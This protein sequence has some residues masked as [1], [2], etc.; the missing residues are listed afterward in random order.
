MQA[1]RS[2]AVVAGLS[3]LSTAGCS[4]TQ[5]ETQHQM[6]PAEVAVARV[7][8][9]QLQNF[10][11]FSG[12]LEAMNNVELHPQVEGTVNAIH[13]TEGAHVKKGELLF[14]ID[15]RRFQQ[16]VGRLQ[17]EERRAQSELVL[18]TS[19]RERSERLTKSGAIAPV[20]LE[21]NNAR[22]AEAKAALDSTKASLS[23]ARLDLSYAGVRAPI[24]G[25]V[26]RAL[27]T[28]GNLVTPATALTTLVSDGALYVYFD[29]DEA[30]YLAISR[31]PKD[32]KI[33]RIGLMDEEGYQHEGS[34]DFLDNRVDPRSG[35]M[36]ARA[37]IDNV[38]GRLMPG[39]FTRV[40]LV[41]GG[42]AQVLLVDDKAVLT[43]QDRKYVYVVGEGNRAQRKTIVIG[44]VADGLR[45]VQ[46]GL[47]PTDRVVVHGVQKIFFPGAPLNPRDIEMGAPP[48]EPIAAGPG[49]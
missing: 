14:E 9:K 47:E 44:R 29:I 18:A 24:D 22:E 39:L 5:A 49:H 48:P 23:L 38:D 35:T 10:S 3:L 12:R 11:D 1:I 13:F 45:V 31:G 27:V 20:E 34:L 43:D 36:H 7:V 33:V 8:S 21:R 16:Q 25:R 28:P 17:A 26:S 32:A 4:Q 40:R 42:S 37:K 15:P 41:G 46:S 30:T 2:W 6:P 19:D